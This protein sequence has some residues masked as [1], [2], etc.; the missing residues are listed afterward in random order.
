MEWTADAISV[1]FIFLYELANVELCEY[2]RHVELD[3][4]II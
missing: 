3:S 2:T 4:K 1:Q